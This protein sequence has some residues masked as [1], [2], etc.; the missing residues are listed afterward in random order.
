MKKIILLFLIMPFII[1]AQQPAEIKPAE[2]EAIKFV[3]EEKRRILESYRMRIINGESFST[4][5]RLHSEDPGSAADGGMYQNISKGTMVA[6]FEAVA[7]KLKQGEISEVFE[8]QYGFHI[9]QVIAKK[10]DALD[11]RHILLMV[12]K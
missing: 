5:A 4:L 10:G 11:L 3:K 12:G 8:T 7:F 2:T 1:K 6:E 9:V